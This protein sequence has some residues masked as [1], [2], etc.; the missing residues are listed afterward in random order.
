MEFYYMTNS[1]LFWSS[2][3]DIFN[4]GGRAFEEIESDLSQMNYWSR[5][6]YIRLK[7]FPT[8]RSIL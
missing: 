4:V 5:E 2:Y 7:S 6:R 8:V 1:A 3:P